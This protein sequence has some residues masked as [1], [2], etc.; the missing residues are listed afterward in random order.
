MAAIRRWMTFGK[1]RERERE[2]GSSWSRERRIT[3]HTQ[4]KNDDAPLA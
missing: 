1:Q 4:S 3:L 2:K